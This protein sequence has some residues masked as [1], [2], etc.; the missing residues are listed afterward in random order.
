[1][2]ALCD[3]HYCC[4]LLYIGRNH[5]LDRL[6][7]LLQILLLMRSKARIWGQEVWF[8]DLHYFL[9]SEL[10]MLRTEWSCLW[11]V[12]SLLSQL[13]KPTVLETKAFRKIETWGG[14]KKTEAKTELSNCKFISANGGEGAII[15]WLERNASYS[16]PGKASLS[17]RSIL[18]TTF[19]WKVKWGAWGLNTASCPGLLEGK[20]VLSFRESQKLETASRCQV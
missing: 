11:I 10:D 12:F 16:V 14:E 5:G 17:F 4:L 9:K 20:V 3:R 19:T 7:N 2:T 6:T 8:Q 1:M 18:R 13:S 15:W